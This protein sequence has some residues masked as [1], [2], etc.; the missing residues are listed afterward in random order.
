MRL[1]ENT[2]G[3]NYWAAQRARQVGTCL[4]SLRPPIDPSSNEEGDRIASLYNLENVPW[5]RVINSKGMIS[6]R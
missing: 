3:K 1:L 5:Q 2:D 6:H 4:F